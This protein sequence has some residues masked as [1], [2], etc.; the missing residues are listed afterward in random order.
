VTG[1]GSFGV[2]GYGT[3]GGTGV[4][5]TGGTGGGGFGVGVN[6]D[7]AGNGAGVTG[8][9]AGTGP[10]VW[11]VGGTGGGAGVFGVGAGTG[12]GVKGQGGTSGGAGVRGVSS[13]ATGVGV[14]AQNNSGGPALQVAGPAS[15]SRSGTLTVATGKS[16][17]NQTGVT[18]TSASLV[19]VTLQRHQSG[20]YVLA[21]VPN[22]SASSFTVY[23]SENVSASTK[24]AWFIIG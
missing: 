19:L 9:G 2:V 4:T 13:T 5:G 20:L 1:T 8:N 22:V 10:G 18:L 15:F 6:G 11:G 3:G 12:D 24:V 21:A 14:L 23:L 16:S 17:A 7:G